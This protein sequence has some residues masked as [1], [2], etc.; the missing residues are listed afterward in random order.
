ML[1]GLYYGLLLGLGRFVVGDRL[2]RL[3]E[4]VKWLGVLVLVLFG[5]MIFKFTDLTMLGIAVKG[6]FGGNGN[7]LTG[8]E[9]SLTFRNNLFFLLFA[10]VASTPLGKHLRNILGNLSRRNTA[11]FWVNAVWEAVHPAALLILSVMALAGDSYN[12]FLYFQF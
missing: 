5:T 2:S 12:P 1:W 4:V 9:V 7:G 10:A 6:L 3:P 8:M 11:C